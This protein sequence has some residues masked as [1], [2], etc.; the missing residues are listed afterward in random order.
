M[1]ACF[2]LQHSHARTVTTAAGAEETTSRPP[3]WPHCARRCPCVS[4]HFTPF[5]PVTPSSI[6]PFPSPFPHFPL[7]PLPTPTPFHPPS[8]ILSTPLPQHL[9][10]PSHSWRH[11][12]T[13]PA[14]TRERKLA[15]PYLSTCL[16]RSALPAFRPLCKFTLCL[17]CV[18]LSILA[19]LGVPPVSSPPFFSRVRLRNL[20]ALPLTPFPIPSSPPSL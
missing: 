17:S 3:S 14:V 16:R 4:L 8:F 18:H 9:H 13:L 2:N 11:S 20:P 12:L 10:S 19:P 5:P 15:Y 7:R 1:S 6:S